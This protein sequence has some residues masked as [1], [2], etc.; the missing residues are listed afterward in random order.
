MREI[1]SSCAATAA[2]IGDEEAAF[3]DVDT[4][5][6][7]TAFEAAAGCCMF[8]NPVLVLA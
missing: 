6:E 8:I 4:G 7:E 3:E 5:D 2:G 1:L